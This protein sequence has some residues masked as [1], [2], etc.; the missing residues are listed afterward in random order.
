MGYELASTYWGQGIMTEALQAILQFGF[1]EIDLR[2]VAAEVM[3]DNI[4]SGKLL[5]KLGFQSQGVLKQHG[6][7]KGQHH[8]LEQFALTKVESCAG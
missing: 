7:W 5:E 6:F 3:L 4:A 8:D 1:E 2:F